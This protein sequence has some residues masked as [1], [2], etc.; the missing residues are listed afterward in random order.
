MRPSYGD[1]HVPFFRLCRN[2]FLEEMKRSQ[3]ELSC[4]K[5]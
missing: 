1:D 5:L 4:N 2:I 3:K